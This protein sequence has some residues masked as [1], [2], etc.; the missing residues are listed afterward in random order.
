MG[1]VVKIAKMLN[2]GK[3]HRGRDNDLFSGGSSTGKAHR[4]AVYYL[5]RHRQEGNHHHNDD[6][7]TY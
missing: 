1:I 2:L 7:W 4:K 6:D 3:T 5:K